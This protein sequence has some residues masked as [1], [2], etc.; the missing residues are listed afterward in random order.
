MTPP[1]EPPLWLDREPEIIWGCTQ[2]EI[3]MALLGGL[4]VTVPVGLL[5]ALF[6]QF[7]TINLAY[8]AIPVSGFILYGLVRVFAVWVRLAKRGRPDYYYQVR[9]RLWRA[10]YGLSKP[11]FMTRTGHWGLQR[12][13][14]A[15]GKWL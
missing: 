3:L 8:L 14:L 9:W 11:V 5:F 6:A 10:R 2:P 1:L 12:E 15:T 7:G 4:L 13:F